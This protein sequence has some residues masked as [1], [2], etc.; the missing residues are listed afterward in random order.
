M[1]FPEPTHDVDEAADREAHQALQLLAPDRQGRQG[2]TTQ[3]ERRPV[4]GETLGEGDLHPFR[5]HHQGAP[6]R[7]RGGQ[8]GQQQT[9]PQPV[10][11]GQVEVVPSDP[12]TADALQHLPHPLVAL[13]DGEVHGP[14]TEVQD[15]KT[16]LPPEGERSRGRLRHNSGLVQ[17]GRVRGPDHG[18]PLGQGKTGGDR[19][20]AGG[21]EGPQ[22]RL[23]VLPEGGE[24][25]DEQIVRR[26]TSPIQNRPKGAAHPALDVPPDV[27]GTVQGHPHRV[28]PHV[29]FPVPPHDGRGREGTPSVP[30]RLHGPQLVHVGAEGI[31][32][33]QIDADGDGLGLHTGHPLSSPPDAESMRSRTERPTSAP[34]PQAAGR[35]CGV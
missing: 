14:G 8:R 34:P 24:Q 6:A 31:A 21:D 33:A 32:R 7:V 11:E 2:P 22:V 26:M 12:V 18:L 28:L 27:L 17:P 10:R 3:W 29:P 15:Q 25:R 13:D 20:D 35:K 19:Q 16:A 4:E 30:Y 5:L 9:L 1:P 23:R